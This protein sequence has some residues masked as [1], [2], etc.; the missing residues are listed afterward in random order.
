MECALLLDNVN[1]RRGPAQFVELPWVI[2]L[3]H[4]IDDAARKLRE[5]V[6]LHP[7]LVNIAA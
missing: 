6:P 7:G 4:V 5:V 3:P 2:T 1:C